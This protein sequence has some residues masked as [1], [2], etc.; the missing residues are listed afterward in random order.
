MA[1]SSKKGLGTGDISNKL[2][3]DQFVIKLPGSDDS[4]LSGQSQEQ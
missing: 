2:N 3:S 1:P 4:Q